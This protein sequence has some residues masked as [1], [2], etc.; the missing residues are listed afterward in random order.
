MKKLTTPEFI[1]KAQKIHS[2]KYDYTSSVYVLSNQPLVITCP[3]HGLF[4]QRPNDH[5]RGQ[6][7]PI[8]GTASRRA[9][10]SNGTAKFISQAQAVHGTRYDYSKVEYNSIRS[11]V[12]IICPTHGEF[13]QKP[14]NHISGKSG[15]PVCSRQNHPGRYLERKFDTDAKQQVPGVFYVMEFSNA[16]E[17][18]IKIGVTKSTARKRH[19]GKTS[20]YDT[21]VLHEIKMTL[22][23]AVTIES[24]LKNQLAPFRYDPRVLREGHTECFNFDSL[25][26]IEQ[27]IFTNAT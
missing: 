20:G 8:C 7:C 27:Q 9:M 25:P 24:A 16:T 3:E 26:V 19:S 10:R 1:A 15:C 22:Y 2:M 14:N 23:Q 17:R 12:C 5:L 18:F 4:Y 21:T 11:N 13:M 6:G